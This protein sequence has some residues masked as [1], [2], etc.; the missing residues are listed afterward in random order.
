M[1]TSSDKE[2]MMKCI[3]GVFDSNT[4]LF[5]ELFHVFACVFIVAAG[6]FFRLNIVKNSDSSRI[7][8]SYFFS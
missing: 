3:L 5:N 1:A 8:C 6:A 2:N 7:Y 4:E